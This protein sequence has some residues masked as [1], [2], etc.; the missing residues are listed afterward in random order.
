MGN[1]GPPWQPQ[2]L[3]PHPGHVGPSRAQ[4]RSVAAIVAAILAAGVMIATAIVVAGNRSHPGG[5]APTTPT[6][7]AD[8]TGTPDA[9]RAFCTD[10]APL[11]A[12]SDKGAQAFSRLDKNTPD[13]KRTG[14]PFVESTKAWVSRM[15]LVIDSHGD[16]DPFLLR[17]T[18]R[19]VDDLRYLIDDLQAGGGPE[20]L[21]Y[22]QTI[23]NDSVAAV[24]GPAR[25]CFELGVKW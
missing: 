21:P 16:A 25:N 23:W 19:F 24:S 8:H 4:R 6:V 11:M 12:E 2:L 14:Q 7:T 1:P 9:N 5:S 22:D 15:Q 18:Q 3:P 13:F 17:S 20:W 10:L